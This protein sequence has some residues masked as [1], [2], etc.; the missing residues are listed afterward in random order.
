MKSTEQKSEQKYTL[1]VTESQLRLIADCVEDMSRFMG[2]Q[3]ELWNATSRLD[4]FIELKERL[5]DLHSLVTPD[6]SRNASYGWNGGG[7]PNKNQEEFIAKTYA[8]YREIRHKM[9]ELN[10][11]PVEEYDYCVYDSPTLTCELGGELPVIEKV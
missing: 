10:R 3:M 8:I 6:L 1:T 7:C 2:G 5:N 9:R 4:N 11:K